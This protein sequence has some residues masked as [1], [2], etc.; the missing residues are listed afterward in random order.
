MKRVCYLFFLIALPVLETGTGAVPAPVGT[1]PGS[2]VEDLRGTISQ[3]AALFGT[4]L[5]AVPDFGNIPLYFIPNEGQ[6][7]ARARFYAKTSRYT[8]WMTHEGLVF[9]RILR[10]PKPTMDGLESAQ[11]ALHS[12]SMAGGNLKPKARREVSRLVFLSAGS[13]HEITALEPTD[14]KVNYLIGKDPAGWAT[15]IPTSRAVLYTGLYPGI[16]LKVYG[17]E[18]HI[19]YDWIV[20][21]GAP[22]ENVRFEYRDVGGTKLDGEG[23]LL[24]ETQ[25]GGLVH[26]KPIGYQPLDPSR[27]GPALLR[28]PEDTVISGAPRTPVEVRFKKLGATAWGFDVEDYDKSRA[29][30]IDPVVLAYSTYLGGESQDTGGAIAVDGTGSAYVTGS[31]YS[32]NF[33]LKDP[34]QDEYAGYT[35]LFVTKFAPNGSSLIYSTFLGGT[36]DSKGEGGDEEASGIAVDGKGAACI[37]GNTNSKDFPLKNAIQGVLRGSGDVFIVKLSA[38]GKSLVFSTYLGGGSFEYGKGIAVGADGSIFVTGTTASAN[39]PL[40]NPFRGIMTG[41]SD[42]FV[43]RLAPNGNTRLYSTF[44][45]GG[46]CS[47]IAVDG[48]GNAFLTGSTTSSDFPVKNPFQAKLKGPSDAFIAKIDSS[49]RSLI[50]STYLGGSGNDSGKGIAVDDLGCAYVTGKTYKS[51]DFPLKNPYQKRSKTRYETTFVSKLSPEGNALVYSTYLGGSHSEYPGGI[52]VDD[53]G[54]AYVTGETYSKDFPQKN[55]LRL[56]LKDKA[57]HAY[58]SKFLPGG[59]RLAFSTLLGGTDGWSPAYSIAG[60]PKGAVYVTGYTGCT[61]FP[62]KHPFR[63]HN[64]GNFDAYVTKLVED[65]TTP[66]IRL[67]SPNGGETWKAGSSQTIQWKT[68]G[69]VGNVKIFYSMDEGASWKTVVLSTRNTG[70]Y[71]WT[72]PMTPSKRCLIRIRE[73]SDGD[74]SDAS[75]DVFSIN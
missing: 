44:F 32:P 75:D 57:Y 48:A 53:M 8:L 46:Y 18:K 60:D 67:L 30:V 47:A 56:K 41:S 33:P 45:G 64:N 50:Y 58:I 9:D 15:D 23:N 74:P 73:A 17:V 12:Q 72:V 13:D 27:P 31:T 28:R 35:D 5:A 63:S 11:S 29:L 70:S 51:S 40:K 52:A 25:F 24:I 69:K 2:L 55:Q 21:P 34:V 6:V 49:G 62:V 71:S 61:D 38:S 19:E 22:V 26:R 65:S 68:A 42:G 43:T 36:P 20:Q 39:F 16:D 14:H 10:D 54:C 7:D 4:K 37:T 66:I 59:D 1:Q 3:G